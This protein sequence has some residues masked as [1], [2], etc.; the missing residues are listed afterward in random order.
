MTCPLSRCWTPLLVLLVFIDASLSFVA[1]AAFQ[2]KH[3]ASE[4]AWKSSRRSSKIG[5]RIHGSLGNEAPLPAHPFPI[6][7]LTSNQVILP[8]EVTSISTLEESLVEDC[9]QN[10]FGILAVGVFVLGQDE[11]GDDSLA[12]MASFC[13]IQ[14]CQDIPDDVGLLITL[15]CVGRVQLDSQLQAVP[16]FKYSCSIAHEETGDMKKAELVVENIQAFL[17]TITRMEASWGRIGEQEETLEDLFEVAFDRALN[18]SLDKLQYQESR[19]TP[20]TQRLTATSW[21]VFTCMQD[22]PLLRDNYR[23]RA[24]D[25]DN[26]LERLKLAQYAL[27]EK[28]LRLQGDLILIGK[29]DEASTP[30]STWDDDTEL[31]SFQ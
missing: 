27:R 6:C 11:D 24:L 5:S 7:L 4:W 10:H 23:L 14:N 12:Q 19:P 1:F 31:D 15:Q 17:K 30:S 2:H 26:L 8:G 18:S 9:V 21:A 20:Q 22:D 16:H 25:W 13:E 3:P 29:E 28:E